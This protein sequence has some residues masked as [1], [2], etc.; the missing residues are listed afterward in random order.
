M[1][2]AYQFVYMTAGSLENARK[3]ARHLVQEKLAACV[4]LIPGMES[5]YEWK[6]QAEN[7]NELVLIAKTRSELFGRLRE[8][9]LELHD[10]ECPCIV[11]LSLT[12]GHPE[13]LDWLGTQTDR[14]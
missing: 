5:Y 11:A 14:A 1:S 9:V 7:E 10:Y 6:G 3:I 12:D 8:R 2:T 4:N 13:F